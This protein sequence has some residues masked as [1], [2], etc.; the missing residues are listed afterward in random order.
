V[1]RQRGTL[2]IAVDDQVVLEPENRVDRETGLDFG[3]RLTQPQ[4]LQPVLAD[5]PPA[6]I[7]PAGVVVAARV[8]CLHH[9][10]FKLEA[11]ELAIP[12]LYRPSPRPLHPIE[13]SL[14]GALVLAQVPLDVGLA[15]RDRRN[16][17]AQQLGAGT[18]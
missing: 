13:V 8:L 6:R 4:R 17:V 3:I 11:L 14:E 9:G 7:E 1:E 2:N 16:D 18:E 12:G 5:L 10:R 15:R